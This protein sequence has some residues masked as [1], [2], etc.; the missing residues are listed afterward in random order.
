MLATGQERDQ[1]QG[2]GLNLTF[3]YVE[4]GAG[5]GASSRRPWPSAGEDPD[6]IFII[7]KSRLFAPGGALVRSYRTVTVFERSGGDIAVAKT[8][9]SSAHGRDVIPRR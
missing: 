2:G 9:S 3:N 1:N 8:R 6:V 7:R 5:Q 4:V